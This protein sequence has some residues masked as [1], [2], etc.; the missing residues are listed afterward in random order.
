MEHIENESA[1]KVRNSAQ[2]FRTWT[3]LSDSPLRR[4][5]RG[6]SGR[7]GVTSRDTHMCCCVS[8]AARSGS[9][10]T[11]R[12]GTRSGRVPV[13]LIHGGVWESPRVVCGQAARARLFCNQI[14]NYNCK[15][16]L[17]AALVSRSYGISIN[18]R[19]NLRADV[20]LRTIDHMADSA[21]QG[22]ESNE[23]NAAADERRRTRRTGLDHCL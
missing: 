3:N 12:G 13:P 20:D 17:S 6:A 16:S 9:V 14:Y 15:L 18:Y 22:R 5:L 11:A 19:S 2:P 23:T 8:S 21:R 4:S 1:R 10:R 7:G